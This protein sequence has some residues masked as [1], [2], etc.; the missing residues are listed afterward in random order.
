[1]FVSMFWHFPMVFGSIFGGSVFVAH[2]IAAVKLMRSMVCLLAV[3]V[4]LLLSHLSMLVIEEI[5]DI[6]MFFVNSILIGSVFV[7]R[8]IVVGKLM[9]LV[10]CMI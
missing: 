2:L 6:S 9:C 4:C 8:L 3:H 1:M 10:T 7:V 5:V